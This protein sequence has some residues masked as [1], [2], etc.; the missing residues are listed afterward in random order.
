MKHLL[1]LLFFSNTALSQEYLKK[2]SEFNS[3]LDYKKNLKVKKLVEKT[4][5]LNKTNRIKRRKNKS[6]RTY[7]KRNFSRSKFDG[8][9]REPKI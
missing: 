7:K 4:R 5:K 8:A 6:F 3:V 1:L 2:M 9:Q